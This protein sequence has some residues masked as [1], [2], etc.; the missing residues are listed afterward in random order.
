MIGN[1][2]VF[3]PLPV[4][5]FGEGRFGF[6]AEV[7]IDTALQETEI[8]ELLLQLLDLVAPVALFERFIGVSRIGCLDDAGQF[9]Q[10]E[11]NDVLICYEQ[12]GEGIIALILFNTVAGQIDSVA[13]KTVV[14][15][16]YGREDAAETTGFIGVRAESFL[17]SGRERRCLP[18]QSGSVIGDHLP[19]EVIG[20]KNGQRDCGT[21]DAGSKKIS[22]SG[23]IADSRDGGF[24]IQ[25]RISD[26]DGVVERGAVVM[27]DKAKFYIAVKLLRHDDTHGAPEGVADGKIL[28]EGGESCRQ[29]QR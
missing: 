18:D 10:Q 13:G 4:L 1:A 12:R 22:G 25:R 28:R 15:V 2:G 6:G 17:N 19:L 27:I 24:G 5:P 9:F 7:P 3:K 20:V 11:G 29:E 21:K 16:K 8:G 14:L 26:A 23:C